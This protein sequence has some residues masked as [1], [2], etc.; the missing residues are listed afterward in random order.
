ML[1]IFLFV[2]GINREITSWKMTMQEE[3]QGGE[4]DLLPFL[5]PVDLTLGLLLP[6][7]V[8]SRDSTLDYFLRI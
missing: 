5:I 4:N 8:R 3:C 7:I 6:L 1:R 2:R